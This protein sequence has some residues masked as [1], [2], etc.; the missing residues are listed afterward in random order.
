ML[1]NV[2]FTE[3]RFSLPLVVAQ[4]LVQPHVGHP[5]V[6]LAV[7][8][9][10]VRH[11]ELA[12]PEAAGDPGPVPSQPVQSRAGQCGAPVQGDHRVRRHRNLGVQHIPQVE[13]LGVPHHRTANIERL[14]TRKGLHKNAKMHS[15]NCEHLQFNL[16]A[17]EDDRVVVL[18]DI[19]S[20]DLAKLQSV[21]PAV[22]LNRPA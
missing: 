10:P 11:V 8:L 3:R 2:L 17:V 1:V 14:D 21:S 4:D 7:H 19:D 15:P 5:D 6:A 18:I 22:D 9:E 13:R 16:P 20:G 12:R